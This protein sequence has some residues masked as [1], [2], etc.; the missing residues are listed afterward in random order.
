MKEKWLP[1]QGFEE[2]YEVS[3]FGKVR[4]IGRW[5]RYVDG[6][7]R[8]YPGQEL[9]PVPRKKRGNYLVVGLCIQ[10]HP[11]D[12]M[13]HRL[14]AF[15]FIRNPKNKPQVNHLDGNKANCRKDNLEWSTAKENSDHAARTGLLGVTKLSP[16][17]VLL[18]REALETETSLKVVAARFNTSTGNVYAIQKGH[19]WRWLC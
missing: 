10:S 13:V 14:V 4:S 19:T 11:F 3:S 9:K 15:H 12:A 2:S 5:V 16:E 17:T 1:I 8:W 18:I 7:V 6:R